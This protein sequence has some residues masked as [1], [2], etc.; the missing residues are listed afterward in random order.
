MIIIEP[1]HEIDSTSAVKNGILHHPGG[2]VPS[3]FARLN[4][5]RDR[6]FLDGPSEFYP[7]D[8]PIRKIM[9]SRPVDTPIPLPIIHPIFGQFQ[10]ALSTP[11]SRRA[12]TAAASIMEAASRFCL[13]SEPDLATALN[14]ALQTLFNVPVMSLEIPRPDR[15]SVK[16]DGSIYVSQHRLVVL[17]IEVKVQGGLPALQNLDYSRLMGPMEEEEDGV[18]YRLKHVAEAQP[19]APFFLLD[20]Y[21]ATIIEVRGGAF[22]ANCLLVDSLAAASMLGSLADA[23]LHKLASVMHALDV[24]VRSLHAT[25]SAIPSGNRERV[26]VRPIPLASFVRRVRLDGVEYEC[27]EQVGQYRV[28][29]A[30]AVDQGGVVPPPPVVIKFVRGMYGVAAHENVALAG[31]APPLLGVVPLEGGWNAVVMGYL[32]KRE[33]RC[34]WS[35]EEVAAVKEAY[36]TA[37]TGFVHGDLRRDNILVRR[38]EGKIDVCFLDF[39]W[40]GAVEE[41][42]YPPTVHWND[43]RVA[44]TAGT[45]ERFPF[46]LITAE[47]DLDAIDKLKASRP[48]ERP[49]ERPFDKLSGS[50]RTYAE[51]EGATVSL[52]VDL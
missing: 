32:D 11:P 16:T 9:C 23:P 48:V 27:F 39:D 22:A 52:R 35:D 7:R 10:D 51:M 6:L 15:S 33:W 46:P 25:Y 36:H 12:Y 40:A 38:G 42:H 31:H 8:K 5:E 21:G 34:P 37:F 26:V 44:A 18:I 50:K 28:F 29:L 30:R 4:P 41:V 20:V 13:S 1:S 14:G 43:T 3:N 24:C 17:N 45:S 19:S 2:V 49:V 47:D